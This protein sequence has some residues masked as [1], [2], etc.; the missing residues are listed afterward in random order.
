VLTNLH[1]SHFTKPITCQRLLCR[2]GKVVSVACAVESIKRGSTS[3]GAP[4]IKGKRN[5][6]TKEG[7]QGQRAVHN[8]E[9]DVKGDAGDLTK[10][11][12]LLEFNFGRPIGGFYFGRR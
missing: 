9:G 1:C 5:S 12:N 11:V 4:K 2:L 3:K 10:R 7:R 6:K 8:I